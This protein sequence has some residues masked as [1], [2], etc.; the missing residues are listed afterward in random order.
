MNNEERRLWILNDEGL[1]NLHR[2]SKKSM[3]QFIKDEKK[4]LDEVID[5]VATGKK[6]QHYLAYPDPKK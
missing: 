3:A 4:T 2:K 5:N 1:Y 6:R